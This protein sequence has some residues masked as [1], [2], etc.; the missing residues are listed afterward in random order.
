M[1]SKQLPPSSPCIYLDLPTEILVG[2][3]CCNLSKFH[4]PHFLASMTDVTLSRHPP[5]TRGNPHARLN[6]NADL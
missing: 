2:P 3:H 4:C 5:A 6:N 1:K